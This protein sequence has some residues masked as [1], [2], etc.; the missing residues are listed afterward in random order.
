M[1]SLLL[2]MHIKHEQNIKIA[3]LQ[4]SYELNLPAYLVPLRNVTKLAQHCH[5]S[6]ILL[7]A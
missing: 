2:E 6:Y 3:A 1:P 4:P 5:D 7:A